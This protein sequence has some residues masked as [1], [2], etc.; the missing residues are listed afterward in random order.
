MHFGE[1]KAGCGRAA[2]DPN[3]EDPDSML[4]AAQGGVLAFGREAPAGFVYFGRARSLQ[5]HF[6]SPAMRGFLHVT[7]GA[8]SMTF[9]RLKMKPSGAFF[10]QAGVWRQLEVS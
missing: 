7:P 3:P 9:D 2:Q 5:S 1:Q 10:K 6:R 8:V 4:G